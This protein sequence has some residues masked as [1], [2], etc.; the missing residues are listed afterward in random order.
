MTNYHEGKHLATIKMME[1]YALTTQAY[2]HDP[3][4]TNLAAYVGCKE[5]MQKM[6]ESYYMVEE[7]GL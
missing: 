7:G 4:K 5:A 1:A 2:Y 6:L 3:S